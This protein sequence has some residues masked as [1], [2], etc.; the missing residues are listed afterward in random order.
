MLSL[1]PNDLIYIK[2]Y[3]AAFFQNTGMREVLV[4][5]LRRAQKK[6]MGSI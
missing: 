4:N 3:T 6:R 2:H 1:K 5:Q